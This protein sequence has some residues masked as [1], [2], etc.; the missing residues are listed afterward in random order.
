MSGPRVDQEKGV[1]EEVR[2]QVSSDAGEEKAP[3]GEGEGERPLAIHGLEDV[4][5]PIDPRISLDSRADTVELDEGYAHQLGPH[6]HHHHPPGYEPDEKPAS[7]KTKA[8]D[9]DVDELE[10][11]EHEVLYVEFDHGDRRDPINWPK[12]RKWIITVTACY[13]TALSGMKSSTASTF[14]MGFP[15]MERDL[16]STPFQAALGLSMYSL[17]FG[18]VP[19][20]TASLSEE[21]GRQPLYVVCAIG[22]MLMNVM[23]AAARNVQ[24]VIVGRFLS[25]A[26]GSTGAT[27]VGGTVADIWAPAERGVPMSMYA[28]SAIAS[29]GVGPVIAGWIEMRLGWRWIQWLHV[30]F[31]G[32]CVALILLFL[33]ET[34]SAVLL[35]RLAKKMRKETGDTRYRARAEDERARLRTLIYISCTRPL[36]LLITEPVVL[37]FSVWISFAWGIMYTMFESIAPIFKTLHHF[38]QG[39]IGLTFLG[40]FIGSLLGLCTN[41]YQER[42]YKRY[43]KQRG[44]EARLYTACG[45]AVMFPAGM[46]IYAWCSL[47]HVPWI[48]LVI[49]VTVFMWATFIMYLAVFTYLADC[50]GPFASSALAGQSLLRNL[51]GTAFP[52]FTTAMYARLTYKWA[53]TV[54]ALIAVVMIPIPYVLMFYGPKIRAKSRFAS[55]IVH[56]HKD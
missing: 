18:V 48:A 17:G 14:S 23:L 56:V 16:H 28:F 12:P 55:Q 29:T 40:M 38:N 45:A 33:R 21:F 3:A 5:E 34:R 52:L 36:Y 43:V 49:G 27:M 32:L 44:P 46:F 37:S 20:A 26:F 25:G 11:G 6:R 19:L 53:S 54:F 1:Q 7:E 2:V 4:E 15:S 22:F 42:L 41:F 9:D 39:E 30:I 13:F 47:P 51:M 31:G 24:T 35:T 10:K 50:Y 8:A